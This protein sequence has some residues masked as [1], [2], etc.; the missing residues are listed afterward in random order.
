MTQDQLTKKLLGGIDALLDVPADLATHTLENTRK[1]SGE[2]RVNIRMAT[3]APDTTVERGT[4]YRKD[5]FTNTLNSKRKEFEDFIRSVRAGEV[6]HVTNSLPHSYWV[7][8]KHGDSM[9]EKAVQIFPH[10]AIKAFN[11]HR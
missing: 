3:G 5:Y 9:F 8:H 11:E 7:E 2:T 10:L 1:F 4:E 6:V